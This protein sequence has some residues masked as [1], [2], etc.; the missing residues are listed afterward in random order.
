MKNRRAMTFNEVF[1]EDV[2]KFNPYHGPDGRFTGPGG[3]TSFTYKPGHGSIYDN[4]IARE[5][6]R[7]VRSAVSSAE[8]K[9]RNQRFETATLINSNGEVLFAKDGASDMVQ[10]TPEEC[11]QMAGAI[12][13]HN[14]PLNSI[15][16]DADVTLTVG[17]DLKEMRATTRDGTHVLTKTDD[18]FPMM[19]KLFVDSYELA[20][21]N[22]VGKAQNTLDQR[23]FR[24]KI[25]SGEITQDYA[26]K[27]MTKLITESVQGFLHKNAS[28]FGYKYSFEEVGM[29]KS[30]TK[31]EPQRKSENP[32]DIENVGFLLDD[33]VPTYD[34]GQKI[35]SEKE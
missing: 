15:F 22:A 24:E 34:I 2:L 33:K 17:R 1:I 19:K 35:E 32:S 16:S 18:T 27:E 31:I 14:H 30:I 9:N 11:K 20:Y 7:S 10:F 6:E 25:V 26:N 21:M 12:L 3:A 8:N 23:G 28:D 29:S 13:T 5:K 4:A